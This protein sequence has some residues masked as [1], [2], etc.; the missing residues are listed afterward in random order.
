MVGVHIARKSTYTERN[1]KLQEF[2]K[3]GYLISYKFPRTN[4]Q[5]M[6][7]LTNLLCDLR[8]VT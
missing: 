8:Q 3:E 6:E 4:Q 2:T 1:G 7:M 5:L